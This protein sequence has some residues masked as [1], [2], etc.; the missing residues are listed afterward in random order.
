MRLKTVVD[1]HT[2][3]LYIAY[4]YIITSYVAHYLTQSL[5]QQILNVKSMTCYHSCLNIFKGK[6]TKLQ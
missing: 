1:C 6:S 5:K 4:R 3:E 2:W